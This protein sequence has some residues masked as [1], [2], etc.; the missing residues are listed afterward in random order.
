MLFVGFML[1]SCSFAYYAFVHHA[2]AFVQSKDPACAQHIEYV[3]ARSIIPEYRLETGRADTESA[4]S[5]GRRHTLVL[6]STGLG[7]SYRLVAAT[8]HAPL[9]A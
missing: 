2:S 7:I 3:L 8:A 5:A 1:Q 6:F 4:V 9:W